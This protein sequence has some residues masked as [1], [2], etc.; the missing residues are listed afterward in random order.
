MNNEIDDYIG[1]TGLYKYTEGGKEKKIDPNNP[2][3]TYI[4]VAPHIPFIRKRQ[5]YQH[6][7]KG[8]PEF[9][10]LGCLRFTRL[11]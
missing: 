8:I 4:T 5:I 2:S 6:I 10:A 9:C 7:A 1:E 11:N 3:L